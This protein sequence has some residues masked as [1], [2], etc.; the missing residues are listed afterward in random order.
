VSFYNGPGYDELLSAMDNEGGVVPCQQWPD[1]FFPNIGETS[2][3]AKKL[4]QG[5]PIMLQCL[6]YALQAGELYGVWGGASALERK[7]I[8]K[9]ARRAAR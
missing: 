5:C 6:A 1:L 2:E 8:N 7:R 9:N 4:C 3:P